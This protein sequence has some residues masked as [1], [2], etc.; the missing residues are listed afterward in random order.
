MLR[1]NLHYCSIILLLQ[2]NLFWIPSRKRDLLAD[3]KQ[4]V[5]SNLGA[6][7]SSQLFN[8][9][10][11]FQLGSL[12]SFKSIYFYVLYHTSNFFLSTIFPP[13]SHLASSS[14]LQRLKQACW[15]SCSVKSSALEPFCLSSLLVLFAFV[16]LAVCFLLTLAA[17]HS[18]RNHKLSSLAF[19]VLF[20][21]V[22][23]L[24]LP[25]PA[26]YFLSPLRSLST[27][28]S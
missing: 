18:C 7:L 17:P 26:Q 5:V 15:L 25:I 3:T 11:I 22:P 16:C 12:L 10:L 27:L 19:T 14:S 21:Y 23:G 1:K 4:A 9:L 20:I 2:Q 24:T 6:L 13:H 28:S 8:P